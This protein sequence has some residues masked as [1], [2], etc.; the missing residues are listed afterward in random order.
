MTA[1]IFVLGTQTRLAET[2]RFWGGF[3]WKA[4]WKQ[5]GNVLFININININKVNTLP[6]FL[7]ASIH[8]F[9]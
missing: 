9:C 3:F 5:S 7:F 6:G 2:H 4:V 1:K 8:S